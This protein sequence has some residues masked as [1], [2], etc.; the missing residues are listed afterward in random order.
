MNKVD[1]RLRL[2][3]LIGLVGGMFSA[4]GDFLLSFNTYPTADNVYAALLASCQH[5]SYTRL[6]LSAL[7][8]G[9]GIPLQAFGLEAFARMIGE[10]GGKT[11]LKYQKTIRVG[12]VATAL[13]GGV[14]HLLCVLLMLLVKMECLAGF[15]VLDAATML[16]MFPNSTV[17]FVVFAVL[18]LSALCMIPYFVAVLV[19]F[20]AVIKKRTPLPKWFCLFSPI[21]FVV[22]LQLIALVFVPNNP[23][24]N[25]LN[26]ANKALG[27]I[28]T[29]G[30]AWMF[31]MRKA[32]D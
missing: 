11:A 16:E 25:G 32:T 28:A 8:G 13:L 12:A 19:I 20:V 4:M 31:Q 30:A 9:V 1:N 6:A 27:A 3:L 14:V 7:C 18:P 29:F 5:L 24:F 10:S 21:V 17:P 22:L 26:M 23:L 15:S 2:L